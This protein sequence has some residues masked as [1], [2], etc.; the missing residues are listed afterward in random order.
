[1][2]GTM[3]NRATGEGTQG[4]KSRRIALGALLIAACGI[5]PVASAHTDSASPQPLEYELHL[6]AE[7][8]EDADSGDAGVPSSPALRLEIGRST[9]RAAFALDITGGA[10]DGWALVEL[11]SCGV[12][13]TFWHARELVRLDGAGDARLLRLDHRSE[14]R[15]EVLCTVARAAGQAVTLSTHIPAASEMIEQTKSL[16]GFNAPT[17]PFAAVAGAPGLVI[18]EIM[19]DPAAV[20][21]S[22]GEWFEVRNLGAS[23]IDLSGWSL[24]DAGSNSHTIPATANA[25]VPP[26]SYFVFGINSNPALNGGVNVGYKYSSFTLGNGADDIQIY[27]AAGLLVDAVAYDDGV[28]WP[29]AAGKSLN[30]QRA[31]V[32]TTSN[33]DG[34]NWCSALSP[35][36]ATSTDFGTPR[37]ANNTCP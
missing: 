15:I 28:L 1:M 3:L 4:S 5:A 35:L 18:T 22:A 24:R 6:D 8:A 30:L 37:L 34:A 33:D 21:D 13:A 19:K 16:V 12:G 11:R 7:A 31:L 9:T 32:D 26:R 20:A 14:A 23:P 17:S 25:I 27:D 10:P 36:S 2:Q 29:D